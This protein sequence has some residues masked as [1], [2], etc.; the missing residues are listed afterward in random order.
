MLTVYPEILEKVRAFKD[1]LPRRS[2]NSPVKSS[3]PDA[4]AEELAKAFLGSAPKLP[5]VP[6]VAGR[7]KAKR[8]F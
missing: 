4:V 1:K 3:K 6:V 7:P 8:A 2:K 5:E